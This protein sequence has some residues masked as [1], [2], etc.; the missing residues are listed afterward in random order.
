MINFNQ[1]KISVNL[2]YIGKQL[3]SRRRQN[4]LKVEDIAAKLNINSKYITFLEEGSFNKLPAGIYGKNFLKE[5]AQF[6]NLETKPLLKIYDDESKKNVKQNKIF[7]QKATKSFRFLTVP[8]IIKNGLIAIIIIA[9]IAYLSFC[10]GKII[11]P[12]ELAIVY[13]QEDITIRERFIEISGK[14]EKEA[15]IMINGELTLIDAEGNFIKNINL[16]NGLNIILISA[17]KKY[18]RKNNL[19]R[20]IIVVPEES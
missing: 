8:K 15:K 19:I 7:V 17:Q 16:K 10:V 4:K 11:S 3:S 14:T 5:Y 2:E 13:P 12:P 20:K 9:L 6:L 18:S 1:H